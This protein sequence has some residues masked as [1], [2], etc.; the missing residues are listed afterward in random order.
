MS[1][2]SEYNKFKHL[3]GFTLGFFKF[4]DA[5]RLTV[6]D[7]LYTF[8][9]KWND[10]LLVQG[11]YAEAAFVWKVKPC[12]HLTEDPLNS[13]VYCGHQAEKTPGKKV[14]KDTLNERPADFVKDLDEFAQEQQSWIAS[15][16]TQEQYKKNRR[17]LK[18]ECQRRMNFFVQQLHTRFAGKQQERYSRKTPDPYLRDIRNL[19]NLCLKD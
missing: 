9:Y 14:Y 17:M 5:F 7:P 8:H 11:T 18:E 2:L 6:E 4:F 19:A 15:L 3:Q 1:L 16:E 13:C 12:G 10:I